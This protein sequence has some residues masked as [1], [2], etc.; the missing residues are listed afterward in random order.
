MEHP[1]ISLKYIFTRF[2][3]IGAS[4]FGGYMAL[5]AV[6]QK[7]LV[8]EDKVLQD[9]DILSVISIASV[10]PGPL[11]VNIVTSLGYKMR[12]WVGAIVA[13]IAVLF[14]SFCIMI[15]FAELYENYQDLPIVNA[16]LKGVLPVVIGLI[17]HTGI[18]MGKKNID[19]VAQVVIGLA[20]IILVIAVPSFYILF[21]IFVGASIIGVLLKKH[22]K[23]SG[24]AT[25]TAISGRAHLYTLIYLVGTIGILIT[26]ASVLANKTPTVLNI[27]LTFFKVSLTLFGGGYV[28]VPILQS[29]LVTELQWID[30][31][32]FVDSIAFGQITPGPILVSATFIGYKLKGIVGAIVGTLGIFVPS[33]VLMVISTRFYEAIR[34]NKLVNACF[35]GLKPAV[36][37]LIL[38][39]SYTI[40]KN[41]DLNLF[42]IFIGIATILSL[43]FTKVSIFYIL[44]AGAILGILYHT[45][46]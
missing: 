12:G 35:Y 22:G 9:D 28:M 42:T 44:L 19:S 37:G 32:T 33:A 16:L 5:V 13:F 10:L 46:L 20:S 11:A 21:V 38:A 36:I 14:P 43:E 25:V 39:S 23:E 31:A 34:E 30:T 41:I 26:L 1:S 45:L 3:G 4:A 7:K 40:S 15:L 2:L 17:F 24:G 8:K 27:G 29:L 18:K 6:V